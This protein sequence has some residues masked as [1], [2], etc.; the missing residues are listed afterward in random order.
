MSWR[1]SGL[2]TLADWVGS[3]ARYFGPEPLDTPLEVYWR[4]TCETA[5]RAI[6]DKGLTPLAPVARPN[7]GLISAYA[8]ASPRPMQA[9]AAAID[10]AAGPQL[11][12]IEDA[13][14]SGKTEAAMLLAARMVAAG[15]GEGVY[16]ALPTMATAN[17]MYARLETME[18]GLFEGGARPASRILAH[19]KAALMRRQATQRHCHVGQE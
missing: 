5:E 13:T 3:D 4:K 17:A 10:L 16:V 7:L 8:G 2:I 11:A 9:A 19:G 12:L 14:G 6:A 1:L 18:R 15:L